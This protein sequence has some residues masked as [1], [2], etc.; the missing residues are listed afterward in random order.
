MPRSRNAWRLAVAGGFVSL[1]AAAD[2][3]GCQVLLCLSDPRGARTEA[4]CRPPID[5]LYRELAEGHAFPTCALAGSPQTGGA[6]APPVDDPYDPCPAGLH[7]ATPGSSVV[8]GRPNPAR[9]PAYDLTSTPAVSQPRSDGGSWFGNG[10][11]ACVG[12]PVGAYRIGGGEEGD[13]VDVFDTVVWQAPH[14]PRAI[15]IYIDSQ[16]YQRV[17]Y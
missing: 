14:S 4:A 5:R 17:R 10:P 13:T 8:Q 9:R 3:W 2:E 15:D 1:T 11:R 16:W 12:H 6:Y 7:V